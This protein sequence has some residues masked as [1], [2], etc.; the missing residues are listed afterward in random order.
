MPRVFDCFPFFNELDL[1][2]IRLHELAPVVDRF[3]IAE[4]ATTYA[5]QPKPLYFAENRHRFAAFADRI[6]HIVVDDIPVDTPPGWQRQSSQRDALMRGLADAGPDDLIVLSDV[7]EIPRADAVRSAAALAAAAKVICFELRMFNYFVNLESAERWLRNG[8]RAVQR[9]FLT[10]PSRLRSVRGPSGNFMRDTMRGLRTWRAM[11]RP[12]ARA[13]IP[14]AGWHFTYLGGPEAMHEKLLSFIGS[15]AIAPEM[16][17]REYL[18]GRVNARIGGNQK[19]PA[20][21]T[22]RPIDESFPMHLR[23]HAERFRRLIASET[24]PA[25]LHQESMSASL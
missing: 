14:D 9:R 25:G 21:L 19:R 23:M 1:L 12:M 15:E 3:V 5:G 20:P 18:T 11:G 22:L 13:V 10:T 2:E 16:L 8:P 4:A 17:D 7:D 6:V 24:A